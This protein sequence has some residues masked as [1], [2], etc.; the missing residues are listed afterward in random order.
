MCCQLNLTSQQSLHSLLAES[1]RGLNGQSNRLPAV[2]A[3][4]KIYVSE[5]YKSGR[6]LTTILSLVSSSIMKR[7]LILSAYRFAITWFVCTMVGCSLPEDTLRQALDQA[8]KT[9]AAQKKLTNSLSFDGAPAETDLADV[10]TS[11]VDIE[12]G[13]AS[14][15]LDPQEERESAQPSVP[16]PERT[17]PFE[18]AEGI[19]FEA[20][21]AKQ[22]E[23]LDIKLFGFVGNESPKAI[24]SVGGRTKTLQ[25][26]DHWGVL[27]VMDVSPPTV[28]IKANGVARVWSLLGHQQTATP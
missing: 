5:A 9:T 2:G 10:T 16:Y 13:V 8:Q 24:I 19:D 17:N 3:R 12:A 11:V 1:L 21:L 6:V 22:N 18:F 23:N 15:P 27:E 26:G 14:D 7:I 28:R 25:A 4:T 20:P